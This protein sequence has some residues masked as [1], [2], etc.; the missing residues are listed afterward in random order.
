[1][2][3]A[4]PVAIDTSVLIAAERS[5]SFDD[6]LPSDEDEEDSDDANPD[7]LVGEFR[8][9]LNTVRPEDFSS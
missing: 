4:M 6:L 3:L 9:F 7:A 1:M 5:G 8:E 2:L